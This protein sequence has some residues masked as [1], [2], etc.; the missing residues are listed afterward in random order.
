MKRAKKTPTIGELF[1]DGRLMDRAMRQ[2]VPRSVGPPTRDDRARHP[3][4]DR[5]ERAAVGAEGWI[6]SPTR[7]PPAGTGAL[8]KS[9]RSLAF[10]HPRLGRRR[11]MVAKPPSHPSDVTRETAS[12]EGALTRSPGF[13]DPGRSFGPARLRFRCDAVRLQP[14][15]SQDSATA[16][17]P[18]PRA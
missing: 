4:G 6:G 17:E 18:T 14:R 1:L 13:P 10:A 8:T 16:S 3:A 5:R 2:A 15:R 12:G 9:N 11:P 7:G